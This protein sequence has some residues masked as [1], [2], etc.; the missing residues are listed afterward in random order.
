MSA[1]HK[2]TSCANTQNE[3][4]NFELSKPSP[5]KGTKNNN[6]HN[7][8]LEKAY[9]ELEREIFDIKSKL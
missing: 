8:N 7:Q 6:P 1:T 4:I 5:L 3:I 9:E 2:T